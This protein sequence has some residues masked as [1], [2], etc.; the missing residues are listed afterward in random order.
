MF[1]QQQ[2]FLVVVEIISYCPRPEGAGAEYEGKE[3]PGFS[4]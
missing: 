2:G 4:K 3:V 1:F